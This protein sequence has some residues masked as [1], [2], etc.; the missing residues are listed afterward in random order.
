MSNKIDISNSVW[1]QSS[2]VGLNQYFINNLDQILEQV[3]HNCDSGS[4]YHDTIV[5]ESYAKIQQPITSVS[6]SKTH[7]TINNIWRTK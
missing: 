4:F 7:R 5:I 1:V 2:R 6:D 3:I